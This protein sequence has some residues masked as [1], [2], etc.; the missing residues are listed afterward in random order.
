VTVVTAVEI[1]HLMTVTES[2]DGATT[3][4]QE[5]QHRATSSP[6]SIHHLMA[7]TESQE[8]ETLAITT[9]RRLT[10]TTLIRS[11]SRPA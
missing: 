4:I 10:T 3:E 5:I 9:S 11:Q 2:Q 8:G 6:T 7:A 1:Q